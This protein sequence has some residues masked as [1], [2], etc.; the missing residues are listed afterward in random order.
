MWQV[1]PYTDNDPV[2]DTNADDDIENTAAW[3]H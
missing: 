2:N 1:A 3:L